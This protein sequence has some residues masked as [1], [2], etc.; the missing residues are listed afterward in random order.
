MSPIVITADFVY[1]R[2]HGPKTK[3][4]GNYSDETLSE[5]A[6][7]ARLWQKNGK[8]VFIYFDNDQNA[9]AAYNALKFLEILQYSKTLS[10]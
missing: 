9:Y 2:L 10:H 1:V 6:D 4:A 8:D 3:Y 7:R 5:W